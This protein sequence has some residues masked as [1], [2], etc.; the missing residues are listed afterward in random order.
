MKEK[1]T[2]GKGRAERDL[3][4]SNLC[5]SVGPL[6]FPISFYDSLGASSHSLAPSLSAPRAPGPSAS[7]E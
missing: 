1:R 5:K 6:K 7:F 3:A 2:R 4:D